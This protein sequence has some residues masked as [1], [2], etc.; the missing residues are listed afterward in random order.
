MNIDSSD[1]CGAQNN[2][3]HG[4]RKLKPN[5]HTTAKYFSAFPESLI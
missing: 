5:M 2:I 1:T 3:D 4:H